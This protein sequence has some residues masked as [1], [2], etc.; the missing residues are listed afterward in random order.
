MANVTFGIKNTLGRPAGEFEV[1]EDAM[2]VV[3]KKTDP[4]GTKRAGDMEV[5]DYFCHGRSTMFMVDS[6]I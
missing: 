4:S 6:V 2:L 5:G 3:P 1:D